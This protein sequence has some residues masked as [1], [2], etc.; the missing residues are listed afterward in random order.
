LPH[1]D[2]AG[3]N[4]LQDQRIAAN[5]AYISGQARIPIVWPFTS[6]LSDVIGNNLGFRMRRGCGVGRN[7]ITPGYLVRAMCGQNAKRSISECFAVVGYR[8]NTKGFAG[9]VWLISM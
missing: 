9:G 8:S 2:N 7:L 4:A 1:G 6:V 5:V 3:F